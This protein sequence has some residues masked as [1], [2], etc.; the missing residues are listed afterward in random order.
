MVPYANA[1]TTRFTFSS[2]T[3]LTNNSLVRSLYLNLNGYNVCSALD[4]LIVCIYL[5]SSTSGGEPYLFILLID[6]LLLS[7]QINLIPPMFNSLIRFNYIYWEHSYT[8]MILL[9]KHLYHCCLVEVPRYWYYITHGI[10]DS[11]SP[12]KSMGNVEYSTWR[13]ASPVKP[14]KKNGGTD[15]RKWQK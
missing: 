15:N 1:H 3:W 8:Y 14:S 4:N 5:C 7:G 9:I 13:I 10:T 12:L 11:F 2:T 6:D